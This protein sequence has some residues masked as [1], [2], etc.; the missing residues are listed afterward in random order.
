MFKTT[1]QII[2]GIV[3]LIILFIINQKVVAW[4]IKRSCGGIIDDL[5]K[6]RA[7]DPISAVELAYANKK[8]FRF[9][10]RDFRTDALKYLVSGNIVGTTNKGKYYLLKY[11]YEIFKISSDHSKNS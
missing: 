5:Q 1:A 4:R 2:I 11:K 3:F 9:G 10:L 6:Q 7:V 8:I